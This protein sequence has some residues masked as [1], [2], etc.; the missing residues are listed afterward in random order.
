MK[1]DACFFCGKEID[2]K[3]HREHIF[4]DSFLEYLDLKEQEITSSLP[5][6]TVYSKVKVPSHGPCNNQW[7]SQFEQYILCLIRT[8][9][10]NLDHLS[11]L[12]TATGEP[13][14]EA[15]RQ[16]FAQWLAKLYFG[17]IYW[18][19]GLKTHANHKYQR[20]LRGLLGAPEFAYLRACFTKQL[21]FKIPSSLF[22]FRVPDPP[23]PAFR[24][25]FG[26]G[27]PLGLFYIRFRNHLL[28]T[29]LGDAN[30]VRDWFTDQTAS[31]MQQQLYEQSSS[32]PVAYLHPVSQIWAVRE[33][34]PIQPRLEFD[35]S[36]IRDLSREGYHE[37]PP[38]DGEAVN[39]RAAELFQQ[40]ASKWNKGAA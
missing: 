19:A 10:S 14:N 18:E 12:H 37:Q 24:F 34:L 22:H 39:T 32:D 36:G 35:S 9:D 40:L 25:D 31:S 1:L 16:A 13:V 29:A 8:M 27:L 20:W 26:N 23:V 15:I 11:G 2:G 28:V 3:I 33:C 30:L 4:G 6:P 21:A 5:R 7:G 38:I 17:L